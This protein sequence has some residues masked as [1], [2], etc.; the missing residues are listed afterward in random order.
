MACGPKDFRQS[1]G[2][3]CACGIRNGLCVEIVTNAILGFYHGDDI[4][5]SPD[6]VLLFMKIAPV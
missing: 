4:L 6:G 3:Y 1:F 5:L 2:V